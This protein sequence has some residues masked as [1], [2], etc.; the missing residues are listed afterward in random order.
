[1]TQYQIRIE[2][3]A[4]RLGQVAQEKGVMITTAESCT[5][6]GIAYAITDGSRVERLV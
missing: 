6:G 2:T 3:L 1:M 4:R 5:A